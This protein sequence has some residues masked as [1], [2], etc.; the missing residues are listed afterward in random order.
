M[1]EQL[2]TQIVQIP[3]ANVTIESF[4]EQVATLLKYSEDR[5]VACDDEA[6][7]ATDDIKMMATL[8][9]TIDE[10]RKEYVGPLNDKVKSI[11]N[12]FK[13]I[14][15][16]LDQ[17]DQ[18]TRKKVMDYRAEQES[19]Q[20][21]AKKINQ[22]KIDLARREMALNGE[23]SP[24]TNTTPVEVPQVAKFTRGSIGTAG[25]AKEWKWEVEDFTKIPDQ[26]K[27]T[28]DKKILKA[29][30]AKQSIPGIK[31]WQEEKLRVR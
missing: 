28:D 5:I 9:K 15:E 4:Q 7:K 12:L 31:A 22:D 11:N 23:I 19:K 26:F 30:Q 24:D 16:P 14:T 3:E 27:T 18:I 10:R 17:A 8:S 2:D 6:K 1:S 25:T 20:A 21:E 29:I 13:T